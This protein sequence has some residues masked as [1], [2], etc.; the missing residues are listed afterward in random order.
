VDVKISLPAL[1]LLFASAILLSQTPEAPAPSPKGEDVADPS[2][3]TILTELDRLQTFAANASQDIGRLHIENWKANSNA[4]SAAQADASSVQ[5]NLSSALPG[6]IAA[7]REAPD[8]VNTQFVLYRN[9][10][11]LH[12]VFGSITDAARVLGQKG[13]YET[14]S[15]ELH[16]LGSIRRNLGEALEQSTAATQRELKELRTQIA[17]QHEQLAAADATTEDVRKQLALAQAELAK[18]PAPKKKAAPKKPAATA[19]GTNTN[20]PASDSSPQPPAANSTP[21]PQ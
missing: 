13:E 8:N 3:K 15:Q 9:V 7:V 21:K 5:R 2:T 4:K 10:N 16:L 6:I 19:A 11:A 14:L 1:V 12:D 20:A 17:Q 18:K